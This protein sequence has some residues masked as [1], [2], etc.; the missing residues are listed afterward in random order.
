MACSLSV[1]YIRSKS[2]VTSSLRVTFCNER[3][4]ATMRSSWIT[5]VSLCGQK[6]PSGTAESEVSFKFR[7]EQDDWTEVQRASRFGPETEVAVIGGM[8]LIL[9]PAD[10]KGPAIGQVITRNIYQRLEC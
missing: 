7:D 6:Q 1:R 3:S 8:R 4:G 10:I 9:L 2:L 5:L